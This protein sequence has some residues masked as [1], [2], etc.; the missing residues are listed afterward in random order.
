MKV[1]YQRRISKGTNIVVFSGF[2]YGA[3]EKKKLQ[4]FIDDLNLPST[5]EYGVQSCNEVRI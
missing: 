3:K 4:V 2:V 5:D 1:I